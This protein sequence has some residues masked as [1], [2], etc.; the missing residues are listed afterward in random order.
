[1]FPF[2]KTHLS[3]TSFHI[4]VIY[5]AVTSFI[6]LDMIEGEILCF[7]PLYIISVFKPKNDLTDDRETSW[8]GENPSSS[9]SYPQQV[10]AKIINE[11]FKIL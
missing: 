1:M 8:I 10:Q 6:I 7:N 11:W 9:K 3:Y 2:Q 4:F 5:F